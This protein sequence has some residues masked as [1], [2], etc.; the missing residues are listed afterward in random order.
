M[1]AWRH[2]RRRGQAPSPPVPSRPG[3]AYLVVHDGTPVWQ[4]ARLFVVL[5]VFAAAWQL[6]REARGTSGAAVRLALGALA[7]PIGLGV[8]AP[9]V[10]KVGLR[11]MSVAGAAVL[12]GGI[13]LLGSG[14]STLL[15]SAPR[16]SR[17]PALAV[18]APVCLLLIWCLGQSVAATNVPRPQLG[19][20][21]PADLGLEY[22]SVE[23]PATDGVTLS[24]WYVPSRN[25]AAVALLH[26]AGS[27]RLN[28]LD[29]AVVLAR[30]GYGVLIY[31][32]RGHGRSDGRAMDFGWFGDRDLGGA[33]TFLERQHGV[34]GSASPQ[35]VCRWA[36][37]RRSAPQPAPTRSRPSSPKVP[38]TCCRRQGLAVRRVRA[39]RRT[40]GISRA[41]HLRLR[42]PAHERQAADH[43]ARR[44]AAR[45]KPPVPVDRRR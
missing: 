26:G 19:S 36:A 34:D 10:A 13:V 1:G 21:T 28:V 4:L 25:N 14:A 27:T 7:I 12:V 11:P 40:H 44:R 39:A 17:L 38:R 5:T 23:F 43:A 33:V 22:R 42:R 9:H 30:H 8:A 2:G 16:W 15:R 18:I 32:A 35:W 41:A 31:D 24:G 37:S 20:E 45:E 29:H 3:L 6:M